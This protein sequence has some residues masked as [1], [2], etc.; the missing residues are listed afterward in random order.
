MCKAYT[1]LLHGTFWQSIVHAVPMGKLSCM[2][3]VQCMCNLYASMRE[4]THSNSATKQPSTWVNCQLTC[5]ARLC[6]TWLTLMLCLPC[7][8]CCSQPLAAHTVIA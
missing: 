6:W 1:E 8:Q 4:I 3:D 7:H 5:T 2:S